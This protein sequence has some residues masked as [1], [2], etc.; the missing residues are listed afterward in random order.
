MLLAFNFLKKEFKARN[1]VLLKEKMISHVTDL[2]AQ[3]FLFNNQPCMETK[4]V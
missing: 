1:T 2:N 4:H 3:N